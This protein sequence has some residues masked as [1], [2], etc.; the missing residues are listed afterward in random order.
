MKNHYSLGWP[1]GLGNVHT[2]GEWSRLC[3]RSGC[4]FEG[5]CRRCQRTERLFETE[6]T[7]AEL[8]VACRRL[9]GM[10]EREALVLQQANGAA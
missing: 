2:G 1:P 8:T 4:M 9:A 10:L 7:I 5:V 3:I 6:A